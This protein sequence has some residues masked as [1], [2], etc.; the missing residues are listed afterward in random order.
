ML[1]TAIEGILANE[2]WIKKVLSG[3]VWQTDCSGATVDRE[4]PWKLLQLVIFPG[5]EFGPICRNLPC[6]TVINFL[7][8]VPVQATEPRPYF[9]NLSLTLHLDFTNGMLVLPMVSL[10]C[11]SLS[12]V[13][14]GSKEGDFSFFYW[15]FVCRKAH[16]YTLGEEGNLFGNSKCVEYGQLSSQL[17]IDSKSPVLPFPLWWNSPV[18]MEEAQGGW[19]LW[20]LGV[21]PPYSGIQY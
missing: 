8:F 17:P 10:S 4:Q 3:C 7:T 18:P 21:S 2:V 16:W 12:H 1:W 14:G 15:F 20:W 11:S 13:K 6:N 9:C 19:V 5:W